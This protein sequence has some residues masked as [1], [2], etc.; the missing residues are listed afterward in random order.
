MTP[1]GDRTC[2]KGHE[3]PLFVAYH[4]LANRASA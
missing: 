1:Y 2:T 3:V 4:P